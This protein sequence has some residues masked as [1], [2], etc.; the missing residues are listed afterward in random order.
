M[1]IVKQ[2]VGG[3]LQNVVSTLEQY[4]FKISSSLRFLSAAITCQ[5]VIRLSAH[6]FGSLCFIFVDFALIARSDHGRVKCVDRPYIKN[7]SFNY[8]CMRLD[9]SRS[10]T[11]VNHD[12]RLNQR[13]KIPHMRIN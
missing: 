8:D 10:H 1:Y 7:G 11:T 4:Q 2:S 13:V 6:A 5:S 9:D 3:G 12:V